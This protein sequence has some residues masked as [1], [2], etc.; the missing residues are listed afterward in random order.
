MADFPIEVPDCLVIWLEICRI[1]GE[2]ITALPGFRVN[3]Q[4]QGAINSPQYVVAV[5]LPLSGFVE[6]HRIPIGFPATEEQNNHG[7]NETPP[8]QVSLNFQSHSFAIR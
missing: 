4:G 6:P 2:K 7:D 8:N 3:E 5:P 1:P